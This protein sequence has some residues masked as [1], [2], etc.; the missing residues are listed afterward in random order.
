MKIL[1]RFWQV[2]LALEIIVAIYPVQIGEL[3]VALTLLSVLA[4]VISG[5]IAS[6]RISRHYSLDNYSRGSAAAYYKILWEYIKQKRSLKKE[7]P[8]FPDCVSQA[9]SAIKQFLVMA[10]MI[11]V[12]FLANIMSCTLY[13]ILSAL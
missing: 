11:P 2:S 7:P 6:A 8:V 1:K 4:A 3:F 13:S 10:I 12:L 5:A 9:V